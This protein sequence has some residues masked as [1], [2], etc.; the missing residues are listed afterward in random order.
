MATCAGRSGVAGSAP[1]SGAARWAGAA[2]TGRRG[3]Q[4]AGALMELCKKSGAPGHV[5]LS[6]ELGPTLAVVVLRPALADARFVLRLGQ[7]GAWRLLAATDACEVASVRRFSFS[8]IISENCKFKV[9]KTI[10]YFLNLLHFR[11]S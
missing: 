3:A 1:G 11:F 2:G 8:N 6:R 4:T 10:D 9:S 7:G 5:Q